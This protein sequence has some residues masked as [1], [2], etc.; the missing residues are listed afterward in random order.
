M[1]W[2]KRIASTKVL[3]QE[4]V[5]QFTADRDL[6]GWS[7]VTKGSVKETGEKSGL[8]SHRASEVRK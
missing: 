4:Q 2:A 6:S 8:C 7:G 3:R 5:Q 1:F